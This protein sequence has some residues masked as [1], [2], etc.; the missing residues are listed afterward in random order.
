LQHL[1]PPQVC[2]LR[3]SIALGQ[4][5]AMLKD[6]SASGPARAV[7]TQDF[8]YFTASYE[9]FATLLTIWMFAA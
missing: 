6:A 8:H 9:R 4:P 2:S 5:R 7:S 1:N 3:L